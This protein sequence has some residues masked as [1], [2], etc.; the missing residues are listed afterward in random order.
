MLD[1]MIEEAGEARQ[2]IADYDCDADYND[3]TQYSYP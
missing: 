1:K 2:R 3:P